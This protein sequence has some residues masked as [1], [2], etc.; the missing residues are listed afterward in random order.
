MYLLAA[1]R[2]LFGLAVRRSRRRQQDTQ[3]LCWTTKIK[4]SI[5]RPRRTL[6]KAMLPALVCAAILVFCTSVVYRSQ[7]EA[8]ERTQ[9]RVQIICHGC[10]IVAHKIHE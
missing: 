9:F 2:G 6:M 10:T 7:Q 8:K 4:D 5:I 3:L 1:T